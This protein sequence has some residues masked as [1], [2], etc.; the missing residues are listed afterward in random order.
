M[1]EQHPGK[2]IMFDGP[3]GVGK[4]TQLDLVAK[5]LSKTETFNIHQTRILGGTPIGELIRQAFL[6]NVERDPMT[7]HYMSMA[8]MNELQLDTASKRVQGQIVLM[9][10]ESAV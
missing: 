8:M 5:D 7:D 3:D 4:T 9:D 10:K 1:T 6:A 2:L